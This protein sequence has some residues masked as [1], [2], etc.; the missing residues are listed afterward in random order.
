[1]SRLCG[2]LL[3]GSVVVLYVAGGLAL[4]GLP[5]E[6]TTPALDPS[7]VEGY[8]HFTKTGAQAGVDY[9]FT[10]GPLAHFIAPA[11]DPDLY[12]LDLV[13]AVLLAAMLI[14]PFAWAA[15]RRRNVATTL[16]LLWLVFILVPRS[17]GNEVGTCA[18]IITVTTLLLEDSRKSSAVFALLGTAFAFLSLLKFSMTVMCCASMGALVLQWFLP[19]NRTGKPLWIGALLGAYGL[20]FVLFWILAGQELKGIPAYFITS[21]EVSR[22]YVM[23]MH[24]PMN[25][26]YFL[27][28]IAIAV[29]LSVQIGLVAVRGKDAIPNARAVLLFACL[30][31]LLAWKMGVARSQPPKFY[32]PAATIAILLST[33]RSGGLLRQGLRQCPPLLALTF[34][35]LGIL[36]IYERS[37]REHFEWSVVGACETVYGLATPG[38]RRKEYDRIRESYR[39]AYAHPALKEFVGRDTIDIFP[40][41]QSFLLFNDLNYHPR[42][43]FQGYQACSPEL[44]GWNGAFYDSPDAPTYV[45]RL[46]V[47]SAI[48]G[49]FPMSE[50][51]EVLKALYR[52]YRPVLWD[53]DILVLKK[54]SDT[55][56]RNQDAE[57]RAREGVGKVGV[58]IELED[59]G[60]DW[61]LLSLHLQPSLGGKLRSLIFQPPMPMIEIRHNDGTVETWRINIGSIESGFIIN[62][63][64]EPVD[65]VEAW[66]GASTTRRVEAIR[67]TVAQGQDWV[68]QPTFG[69]TVEMV[70]P[71]ARAAN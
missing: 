53:R 35:T 51:A 4:V 22:A 55:P 54:V 37:F 6:T 3:L 20:A 24:T 9:M 28:S 57:G 40:P 17:M 8:V 13:V 60:A 1:M 34:A 36:T 15:L 67:V 39:K 70:P 14:I 41:I 46:P 43:V 7:W 25:P 56:P 33:T 71:L 49:R 16:F 32:V 5:L 30:A 19:E 45:L 26:R 38:E 50:D 12:G 2:W 68:L 48:D 47:L 69:Y 52:N 42:P 10:Y 64:F 63:V 44:A 27:F 21:I 11:Y 66:P 29:V 65:S 23:G 62:P 61:Q 31:L 59:P 18:A 58:W